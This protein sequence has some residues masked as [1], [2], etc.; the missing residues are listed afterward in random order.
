MTPEG[1]LCYGVSGMNKMKRA[2]LYIYN[3]YD[4]CKYTGHWLQLCE[5]FYMFYS[6]IVDL[7]V[8]YDW[9][10]DMQIQVLLTRSQCRVSDTQ[11]A[12]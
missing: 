12:V 1:F 6:A 4:M 8:F 2:K 10:V 7:C 3:F 11:M 9:T 5:Y